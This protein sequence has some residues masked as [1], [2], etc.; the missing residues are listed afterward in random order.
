MKQNIDKNSSDSK[1]FTRSN[2][3]DNVDDIKF[4]SANI[5]QNNSELQNKQ[6]LYL[7][8]FLEA[9]GDCV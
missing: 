1:I 2:L 5:A 3:D 9:Y 4:S 6:T 8:R 7:N